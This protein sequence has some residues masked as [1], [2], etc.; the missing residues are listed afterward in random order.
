MFENVDGRTDDGQTDGRTDDGRPTDA[1]VTGI[2]IAHLGAFGSGELTRIG[3]WSKILTR[4]SYCSQIKCWLC[5]HKMLFR[6]ANSKDSDKTALSLAYQDSKK[7]TNYRLMQ[8]KS[9]AA[10]CNSFDLH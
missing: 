2:L 1:G 7:K 8:V 3:K 6:I 5:Y 4:F 10:F 9:I